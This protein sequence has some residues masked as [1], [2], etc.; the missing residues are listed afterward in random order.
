MNRIPS[1]LSTGMWTLAF[2]G[3][4]VV[5]M[6]SCS[7]S[8]AP[9]ASKKVEQTPASKI[10]PAGRQSMDRRTDEV[11]RFQEMN[12]VAVENKI[13]PYRYVISTER[14]SIFGQLVKASSHSRTIHGSGVTLLC[15]TD[16]AFDSF[17]NWKMMLRRGSQQ[18]LDDFVAN[19]VLP[20]TLT[21]EDLKKKDTHTNLAGEN[22][23]MNLRGGVSANGAHVR[24]GYIPTDRG[25]VIGLDGVVFVP[26]A[27]R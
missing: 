4:T 25:N 1:F 22:I 9:E 20:I 21:Y 18:E 8:S 2:A 19:H 16:E 23:E 14:Y 15:P 24:S 7:S 13:S 17:D 26:F 27:L 3:L 10:S 11:M 6:Q 12:K 5:G